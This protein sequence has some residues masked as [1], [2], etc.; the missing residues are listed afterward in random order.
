MSVRVQTRMTAPVPNI[1]IAAASGQTAGPATAASGGPLAGFEA[2]LAALFGEPGAAAAQPAG[3]PA[4]MLPGTPVSAPPLEGDP[5]D[6]ATPEAFPATDAPA[7]APLD[8]A[9]ALLNPTAPQTAP[10]TG[11]PAGD[12]SAPPAWGHDKPAGAP[13]APALAHA[14]PHAGLAEKAEAVGEEP[15]PAEPD[16][17]QPF[18]KAAPPAHAQASFQRAATAAAVAPA[19]PPAVPTAPADPATDAAVSD[20]PD[21]LA[22]APAPAA[23][24]VP[25]QAAAVAAALAP[26]AAPEAVPQA[27][28]PTKAERAKGAAETPATPFA[29]AVAGA[30]AGKPGQAAAPA[31]ERPALEAAGGR[32]EASPDALDGPDTTP[33][34][35]EA[36]AASGPA[37]PHVAAT[38][39]R[40]APETVATLTAD[41]L[42]KLEGRST[43]FELELQPAGLGRVDVRLDIGAHGRITAAMTFDT[44]QAAAE[45][46]ARAGE[47]QRSLEQAGFDLS[48]GLSFDVAGDRGQARQGWGE[49][50]QGFRGQAFQDALET[51]GEADAAALTG[52]LR[53]R[54]GVNAGVD[55]RV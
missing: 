13:A 32:P 33:V 24:P 40:G 16:A 15:G 23:A 47:L 52:A 1:T 55:M 54:R 37:A 44:P 8:P 48:G 34:A 27:P 51:A 49:A 7:E 4:V 22:A 20:L 53:L 50:G 31:P 28:Q 2:L 19:A 29:A 5:A 45:L 36:R 42:K 6:A 21:V 25:P 35:S 9:L 18:A 39:V 3:D 38:P 30:A 14:D 10:E 12:K 43:R 46:R 41:I 17:A 11:P 26:R